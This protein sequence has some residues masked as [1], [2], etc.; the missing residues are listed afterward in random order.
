MPKDVPNLVDSGRLEVV[1][2]PARREDVVLERDRHDEA[3]EQGEER[4]DA[5]AGELLHGVV[6][7]LRAR[8]NLPVAVGVDSTAMLVPPHAQQEQGEREGREG[9]DAPRDAA[10]HHLRVLRAHLGLQLVEGRAEGGVE[11]PALLE[12]EGDNAAV[13][14][15]HLA[16]AT[17][18]VLLNDAWQR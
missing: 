13:R 12:V 3:G 15:D 17:V 2:L 9:E 6:D 18:G 4:H 14:L 1:A 5:E 11:I 16:V 7:P 10:Q 8:V